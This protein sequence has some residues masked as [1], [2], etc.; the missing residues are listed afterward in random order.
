MLNSNKRWKVFTRNAVIL[1]QV[2][3]TCPV[4]EPVEKSVEKEAK[5]TA[6]SE[7]V[8]KIGGDLDFSD[9]VE[10]DDAVPK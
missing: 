9:S 7:P 4:A 5:V 6:V 1:M 8:L 10:D 2:F 3:I